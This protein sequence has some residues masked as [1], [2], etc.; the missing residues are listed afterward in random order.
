LENPLYIFGHKNPDTDS[1]CSSI[2]YAELKQALGFQKAKAYRLGKTSK[3][4]DFVLDYFKIGSP[5]YLPDVKVRVADLSL[6]NPTCLAADE[7]VNKVWDALKQST[8]CRVVPIVDAENCIEGIISVGDITKLFLEISDESVA[9]RYEILF[10][11]LLA[12]LD[13][14]VVAGNYNYE[15]I[16]G[17]L[18]IGTNI[19]DD[20]KITDKDIILTA[21]LENALKFAHV[22]NCGCV[23]LTDGTK[24]LGFENVK[25]AIVSVDYTMFKT[26][27]MISSAISIRS[28]MNLDG[29]TSFANDSYIDDIIDI[30]KTSK[31]RN[32]PVVDRKGR[33]K[34]V[35]SRRHL[36]DYKAKNVVLIDH[37]EKSQSVDGLEQARITEVIDH[38]RVADIQTESPLYIRSE[39]VG[40]S[41]TIVFKM[42]REHKIDIKPQIAGLLLSAIL[43][44]TL[45]FSSPTCT[46]DDI[47]AANHLAEIADVNIE[48]FGREMFTVSTALDEY[49][50]NEIL[51][52]DRKQFTFDKYCAYI[53]QVNTL[54]FKTILD[55]EK[56]IAEAMTAFGKENNGDLVILMV[57][58]IVAGGSE[59]IATGKAKDLM[60]RAFG[61]ERN[62]KSIFLP[63]VVSR[64]KQVVP[65]LT[66]AV[67]A[68][69]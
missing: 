10:K 69:D 66:H 33:I 24:P 4:T 48:A 3:E 53:S 12:I 28:I 37:N 1:I 36:I 63:G 51:S 62:Q 6:Y 50:V 60:Y 45:M 54:D 35:I 43:S 18:Y 59:V 9:S 7:P 46:Q 27:S 26:V 8:G 52:I 29:I 65:K 64:K 49:S 44:D 38:H 16:S 61:M 30:M 47:N 68:L 57:T 22:H 58:D 2:A 31:H 40:C 55:K 25:T 39:P 23:I 42:Y 34:G 13:G 21:K 15:K 32:F 14:K 19:P 41:A 67:N 17:S 20:V 11:N 5:D 56:D